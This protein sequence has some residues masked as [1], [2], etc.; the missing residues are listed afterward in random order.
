MSFILPESCWEIS[1]GRNISWKKDKILKTNV[2][3]FFANQSLS[4]F[5]CMLTC[6]LDDCRLPRKRP[7][8]FWEAGSVECG[9]GQGIRGRKMS[10]SG[11]AAHVAM[12]SR[13]SSHCRHE[14]DHSWQEDRLRYFPGQGQ[15][16]NPRA[17][18]QREDSWHPT[19]HQ[20][21]LEV[22]QMELI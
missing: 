20:I 15:N 22:N 10:G 9:Q 11:D 13:P 18:I 8:Q 17:Y 12:L 4:F 16:R 2:L 3:R 14:D 5:T 19:L 21:L 7:A 1:R 6:S